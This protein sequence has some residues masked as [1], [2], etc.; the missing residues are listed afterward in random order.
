MVAVQMAAEVA[1]A[2]VFAK[3]SACG[4]GYFREGKKKPQAGRR[5]FC[6]KCGK[7]AANRLAQ[8]D[9]REGTRRN[10]GEES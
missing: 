1:G 8:R 4:E 7:T 3:C 6:P 10:H 2:P 5:N 9:H